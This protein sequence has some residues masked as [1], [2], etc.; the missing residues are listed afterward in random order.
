MTLRLVT[1]RSYKN[2]C[3]VILTSI[4]ATRTLVMSSGPD[5]ANIWAM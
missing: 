5:I 2:A 3:R 1:I 4:G